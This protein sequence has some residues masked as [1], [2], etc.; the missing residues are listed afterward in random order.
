MQDVFTPRL[1][2]RAAVPSLIVD[3]KKLTLDDSR[4]VIRHRDDGGYVCVGFGAAAAFLR[5]VDRETSDAKRASGCI[6]DGMA[7]SFLDRLTSAIALAKDYDPKQPR[8][9]D[10]RWTS[11]GISAAAAATAA[12]YGSSIRDV[13]LR[14]L[15]GRVLGAVPILPE[16]AGA[17]ALAGTAAVAGV[18]VAA[19]FAGTLFMHTSSGSE[20]TLPDAPDFSYRFDQ[21]AGELTVSRQ[22]E[23]GTSEVVYRGR[24]GADNVFRDADGNPVGRALGNTA[25][26]DA[27]AIRGYETRAKSRSTVSDDT[28]VESAVVIDRAEPKLCPDP[29]PDQPGRKMPG[30]IAYQ[31]YVGMIVNGEP[32]PEGLAIAMPRSTGKLTY[33]DDCDHKTG[34]LIDAKGFGYSDTDRYWPNSFIW[35]RRFEELGD[36]AIRQE[37]AA[38][39][40]PIHWHFAEK[41]VADYVRNLFAKTHPTITI[42]YTPPPPGLIGELKRILKGACYEFRYFSD[43]FSKR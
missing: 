30:A 42:I 36:Q 20:G 1:P 17:A 38:R 25:A 41:N 40:R 32:L 2:R 31:M 24:Y 9:D 28:A 3:P 11:G 6:H 37:E 35:S 12:L 23:D 27:D 15:A 39:G 18:A 21:E 7:I 8:D 19:V 22:H 13:A 5:S 10:G 16:V 29:S 26:I 33:F 43:V 14:Q 4:I 34:I